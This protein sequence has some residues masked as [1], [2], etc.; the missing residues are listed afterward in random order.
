MRNSIIKNS[1][2][3]VLYQFLNLI[4]PFITSVYVARILGK[5]IIG[6]ISYT[7]N[8]VV[9]FVAFVSSGLPTYGIREIA[10]IKNNRE[11]SNKLFSELFL[12]NAVF[13][14]IAIIAYFIFINVGS[15]LYSDIKLAYLFALLIILNYINVDW[16]YTGIEE[17]KF[18]S[19]RSLIV[20]IILFICLLIFVRNRNDVYN[21]AIILCLGT[22]LNSVFNIIYIR[23]FVRL[24][25]KNLNLI[26][27]LPIIGILALN[28]FLDSLYSKSD[29]TL[30]GI[31]KGNAD[32][33]IYTYAYKLPDIVMTTCVSVT[34]VFFPR[35]VEYYKENR[36]MFLDLIN[37][38]ISIIFF[39]TIPATLGYAAIS[40]E[41]FL[42]L[43]GEEF[44][45]AVP[46]SC[47]LSLMIIVK[48]LGNLLAYQ[49]IFCTGGEKQRIPI[50]CVAAVMNIILDVVFIPFC[51]AF[52]AAIASV[53]TEVALNVS[54]IVY[55][56]KY[57]K[58]K[59]D[60]KNIGKSLCAGL[61]MLGC[62]VLLKTII[63]NLVVRLIVCII[64]GFLAYVVC[65]VILKNE[66]V[67]LVRD[68]IKS[69]FR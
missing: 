9:Y 30:L 68:K 4:F 25:F 42:L 50:Y 40:N 67:F 56:Y 14:S 53:F 46:I 1:F 22:G 47:L 16:F 31:I 11:D 33:G 8:Y 2:Y 3:N 10:K 37:N 52:G 7:Q 41:I 69:R 32:V 23:K 12:L 28:V 27:H 36:S 60:V 44:K 45:T 6:D 35:L 21:Y 34:A 61:I 19:I 66:I 49:V 18:I 58:F 59:F 65:S 20:K 5:E 13:T 51:G 29:I 15:G 62:V 55:E 26:Q 64:C 63:D 54:L 24:I 57:V 43:Y 17:F 39:I 48:C 38:G